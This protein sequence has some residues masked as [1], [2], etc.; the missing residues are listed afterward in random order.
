MKVCSKCN[1]NKD[2][3][4][5]SLKKSCKDGYSTVCKEC[6][7]NYSKIHY[8]KNK[9]NRIKQI[10][11]NRENNK[12][13]FN[14]YAK[15]W[16][17]KNKEK[18]NEKRRKNRANNLSNINEKEKLYR[19]INKEKINKKSREWAKN[20]REKVNKR[21]REYEAKRMNED[22]LFKFKKRVRD[23]I[24]KSFKRGINQYQKNAKTETILGC[25]INEFRIYIESQFKK[26]MTFE[27]IGQWHL[28]HII[29]L[30]S[31]T[32]EEDIIKLCHY[33]NYQPLWAKDNLIK[34]DKIIEQQLKLI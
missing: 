24:S 20:N 33:T 21:S 28:D 3:S 34:S 30:A 12:E 16:N 18:I 22:L 7:K 2:Y 27:N 32:N 11:T 9:E 19:L 14:L 4:F 5:Y 6:I 17:Q 25:T 15:K 29:P 8:L 23:N 26:G 13:K 10:K 1:V 31:A